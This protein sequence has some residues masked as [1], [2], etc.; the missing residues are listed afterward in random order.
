MSVSF[1]NG[2]HN[3][4]NLREIPVNITSSRTWPVFLNI[5]T[6]YP[7]HSFSSLRKGKDLKPIQIIDWIILE[8]NTI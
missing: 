7:C 1:N 3:K 8:M 2:K 4:S 6:L 5:K